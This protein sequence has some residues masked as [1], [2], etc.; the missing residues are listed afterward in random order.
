MA[1]DKLTKALTNVAQA[2]EQAGRDAIQR[3]LGKQGS[4]QRGLIGNLRGLAAAAVAPVDGYLKTQIEVCRFA[5]LFNGGVGLW[6][7]DGTVGRPLQFRA[8]DREAAA[9]AVR[10]LYAVVHETALGLQ[11]LGLDID[12]EA[13]TNLE[14]LAQLLLCQID[15]SRSAATL[16]KSLNVGGVGEIG[17]DDGMIRPT[18]HGNDRIDKGMLVLSN[19]YR[20][21]LGMARIRQPTKKQTKPRK[22]SRT[23]ITPAAKVPTTTLMAPEYYRI[24]RM[25]PREREALP[26]DKSKT[27]KRMRKERGLD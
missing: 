22:R 16:V 2:S 14:A 15:L 1:A 3:W 27:Y 6:F 13:S 17:V 25:T 23:R 8:Q 12:P 5:Q 11:K 20:E 19:A 4:K 10:N 26:A 9:R 18:R 7:A 21:S 24:E